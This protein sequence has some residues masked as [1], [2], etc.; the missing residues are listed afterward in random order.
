MYFLMIVKGESA[1]VEEELTQ[2]Y[3]LYVEEGVRK[4][5]SGISDDIQ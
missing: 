1:E 2:F 5:N 4:D 3:C